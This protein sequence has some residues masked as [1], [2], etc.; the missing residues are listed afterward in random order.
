MKL[1][2]I[3]LLTVAGWGL[4]GYAVIQQAFK[5]VEMSLGAVEIPSAF[6]LE[7]VKQEAER[8]AWE[9]KEKHNIPGDITHTVYGA[10]GSFTNTYSYEAPEDEPVVTRAPV[11]RRT[12]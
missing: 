7:E 6:G 11:L 5:V 3:A 12:K 2:I 10:E 8:Q 9:W 4:I 1:F